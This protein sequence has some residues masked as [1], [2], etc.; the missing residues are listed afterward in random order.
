MLS[1]DKKVRNIIDYLKSIL[2][3]T[4]YVS[5]DNLNRKILIDDLST[6]ESDLHNLLLNDDFIKK[7]YMH[8]VNS[9]VVIF[10]SNSLIRQIKTKEYFKDSY[11]E[12]SNEIG[13][14]SE[15][16]SLK[17]L[18][19][20]VLNFPYKDAI[21]T[22]GMSKEDVTKIKGK[23][24]K[25]MNM[26][27]SAAETEEVFLNEIIN[28]DD[29][30]SL[31]EPK[32]FVD[33]KKYEKNNIHGE[34]A[35][36]FNKDNLII[37]G[38][39]LIALHSLKKRF[40][41]NIKLIYIDPPYNTG[42]DSFR[43]NDNFDHSTWLTF[44]KNRLEAAKDLLS[45]EGY[46]VIQTDDSEQAYLKVLMDEIF[47]RKNYVNTISIL[48][49]NIAG[50]S[51]GG[52]DKRLK[53]NVEYLTIYAKTLSAAPKFN[54]V[55]KYI[56]ISKHV[57]QLRNDG[58]SWKYTSVLIDPGEKIYLG[59]TVDGSGEE[60][61]IYKREKPVIKS[62]SQLMKE[63]NL[64]EKEAYTKYGQNAF[65]TAMPQ[66]SIR[67]RVME[68][69]RE[70]TTEPNELV[71]IE[72]VPK[73]GKH[74]NKLYEQFYK[75]DNFRLFAWL[76]DVSEVIDGVLYR[77]EK[78]GT[79]WD[80]V[81]E[82]KN[83]NKEGKVL[84]ENGKKPEGLIKN[85]IE[86]TTNENDIVLDFFL[87]SGT[88]A[89]VSH[90]MNRRYI[91]IDQMDYI[92]ALAIERLKYV[93]SGDE[94][95]VSKDV[96]WSDGGSFI[97]AK[98]FDK[99]YQYLTQ[100]ERSKTKEELWQIFDLL[101]DAAD[102]RFLIKLDKITQE[103]VPADIPLVKLKELMASTLKNSALYINAAET[104]DPDLDMSETD[105]EFNKEFYNGDRHE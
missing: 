66:S 88:T 96:D 57:E 82:T 27:F 84:F 75:G 54:N 41:S 56:E 6:H 50:A 74:K 89:A 60:I 94:T 105:R 99:N 104:E 10:D 22:A 78:L 48:F 14:Y 87:G 91:G 5:H 2:K 12:F 34:K 49:K 28:I 4:K 72:Y 23:D 29:I 86:L 45:D 93:I 62:M 46:I 103:N 53:K 8:E 81:G 83:V 36:T 47:G 19:N 33:V 18:S 100:I 98:L 59:S 9:N 70:L 42:N 76:K 69:Y 37:K 31:K 77:K 80:Y 61:K 65:Q 67:P 97:Y 63:E 7:H 58:V 25:T 24:S 85:I 43:Y 90:K 73:S 1:Q 20:V 95:G 13:L 101:R 26:L 15:G 35:K 102:F 68:K 55:Y 30:N 32:A 17:K 11:T 3:G 21:L 52:E 40:E 79:F 64:S 38:N 44:M 92:E 71:S 16:R 39:N 51:G